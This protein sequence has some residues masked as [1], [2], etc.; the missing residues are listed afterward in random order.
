MTLRARRVIATAILALIALVAAMPGIAAAAASKQTHPRAGKGVI[1]MVIRV[2]GSSYGWERVA[3]DNGLTAPYIVYAERSYKITCYAKTSAPAA[4]PKATKPASASRVSA[5]GWTHPLPGARCGDGWGAPRIGHQHQGIDL[6]RPRGTLVLAAHAGTVE[7]VKWSNSAGWYVVLAHGNGVYSLYMHL[8]TGTIRV[9]KGDR[10]KPGQPIAKE[11]S[12][13]DA[14]APH[15]HF[16]VHTNGLWNPRPA[17]DF[18]LAH[19]VAIP[20]WCN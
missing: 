8:G 3:A 16:E 1:D 6:F 13:G 18:L 19:G 5:S 12:T 15:L 4:K 14:S 11:G 17:G 7:R 20:S 9:E 2:C 10:V